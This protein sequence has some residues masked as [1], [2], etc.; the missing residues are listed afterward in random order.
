[1]A[2]PP[3]PRPGFGRLQQGMLLLEGLVAILIFSLGV[4]LYWMFTG[5]LP[6]SGRSVTEITYNVA[7]LHPA[8]VRQLN[9][10]LP[11]VFI[12]LAVSFLY[13]AIKR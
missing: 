10:A 7:H 1:M 8:P 3:T 6:F 12:G 5:E 4:M 13:R 11:A 2:R 9:W